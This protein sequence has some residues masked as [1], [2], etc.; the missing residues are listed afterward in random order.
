[1]I[2]LSVE[3]L[4]D[5]RPWAIPET[6]FASSSMIR[7]LLKVHVLRAKYKWLLLSW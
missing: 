6:P 3:I 7:A 2:S 1:M 5:L 4:S